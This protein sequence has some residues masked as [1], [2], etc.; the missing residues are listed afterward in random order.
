MADLVQIVGRD[1]RLYGGGH[2]I[3]D[4]PPQHAHLA[5]GGLSLSI[6][7]VELVPVHEALALGNTGV[8]VVGT[9][10]GLGHLALRGQG[11]DGPQG[12]GEGEGGEGVVET[13]CWI[14]FRHD[15]G[16]DDVMKNTILRLALRILVRG[17]VFVLLWRQRASSRSGSAPENSIYQIKKSRANEMEVCEPSSS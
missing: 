7:E 1:A 12:A 11:V 10:D 3:Q 9:R 6:E 8:G 14:R 2:D 5:H 13:G 4:F 17:F 16:G 15:L